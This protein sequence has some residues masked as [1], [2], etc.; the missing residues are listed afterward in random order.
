MNPTFS[1]GI[2]FKNPGPHFRMA[3]QSVFAQTCNDWEL[4]LMDDGS[5]DDSLPLAKSLTDPRVR[6]FSDGTSRNLNV[7]LNEMVRLSRGKYFVRM[8]ADDVMHPERLERQFEV[9]RC[10]GSNTVVGSAAYSIDSNSNIIGLRRGAARQQTGFD[11]R[12]SFIH[13]TVAASVDWFRRNPYSQS[14]VYSRAEDAELWCRTSHSSEFVTITEPLLYYREAGLGSFPSYINSKTGLLHLLCERYSRPI[15]IYATRLAV[16]LAKIWIAFLL[17]GA[18]RD[19]RIGGW[20]Y[21]Q[22]P[23]GTIERAIAGLAHVQRQTL[24]VALG[25]DID[26]SEE[27]PA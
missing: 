7:R 25:C 15:P 1:V 11:A 12:Y 21:E 5:T 26:V 13:P 20:R 24:P 23:S 17:R 14:A 8:D 10:S 6:V 4:I 19:E 9:L 3:L 27:L 18:G 2:S 16:E 22:L